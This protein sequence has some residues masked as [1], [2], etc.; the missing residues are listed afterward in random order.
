MASESSEKIPIELQIYYDPAKVLMWR[1]LFS[2]C[3]FSQMTAKKDGSDFTYI[4]HMTHRLASKAANG[5]LQAAKLVLDVTN[6][7]KSENS[8]SISRSLP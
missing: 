1:N 6:I 5:D 3:L 2:A 4:D 7:S 8:I